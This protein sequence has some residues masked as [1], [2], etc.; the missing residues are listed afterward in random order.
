MY[1]TWKLFAHG[2]RFKNKSYI[3]AKAQKVHHGNCIT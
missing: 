2:V 3:S 1:I